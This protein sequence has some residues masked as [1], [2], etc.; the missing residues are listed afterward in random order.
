[1]NDNAAG[2]VYLYS[3]SVMKRFV[4]IVKK[5][6]NSIFNDGIEPDYQIGQNAADNRERSRSV[7]NADFVI[8]KK[9]DKND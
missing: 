2:Q 9:A 7:I 8:V 5:L 1:M 3:Q 6:D 4:K